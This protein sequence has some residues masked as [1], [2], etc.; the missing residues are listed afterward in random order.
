MQL[1]VVARQLY[2]TQHHYRHTTKKTLNVYIWKPIY[3]GLHFDTVGA[4]RFFY[5]VDLVKFKEEFYFF[6]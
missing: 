1:L 3:G 2:I 6:S 4:L 5:K